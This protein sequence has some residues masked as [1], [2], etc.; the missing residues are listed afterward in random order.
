MCLPNITTVL[1]HVSFNLT[2]YNKI[3]GSVFNSKYLFLKDEKP[4]LKGTVQPMSVESSF[5]DLHMLTLW[6]D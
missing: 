4:V 5:A 3:P 1:V 2:Y 6:R